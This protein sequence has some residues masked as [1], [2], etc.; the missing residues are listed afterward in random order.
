MAEAVGI[1][2]SSV[3]RLWADAGLKPHLVKGL[4][5]SNDPEFEEK[6]TDIVGLY[7]D[8]PV[9][10]IAGSGLGLRLIPTG[11]PARRVP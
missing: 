4:K 11:M 7:L 10:A 1:S 8:P 6:V 5:V 3:G 2:P 9:R